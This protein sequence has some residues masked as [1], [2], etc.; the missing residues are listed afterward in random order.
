M[1]SYR[2]SDL[3]AMERVHAA[4]VTLRTQLDAARPAIERLTAAGYAGASAAEACW[5]DDGSLDSLIRDLH[6][7]LTGDPTVPTDEP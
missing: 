2:P 3:D 1:A 7:M 5:E 4:A 6:G